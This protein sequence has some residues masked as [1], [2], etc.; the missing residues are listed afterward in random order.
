[1]GWVESPPLLCAVTKLAR[2]LTQHLVDKAVNL[3]PHPLKEVM[4]IQAVST[5]ARLAVPTKLLQVYVDDFCFATTQLMVETH[6]PSI[7]QAAIH[8]IH[9]FFPQPEVTGHQNEKE[10]I[11]CKKL[12]LGNGDYTSKKDIIG[13]TFDGIKRTFH[14]PP[15]E[16]TAFIKVTHGLLCRTLA[17]LKTLQTLLV[18]SGMRPLFACSFFSPINAAMH[19]G[20]KKIGLGQ[21][22][23]IRSALGDLSCLLRLLSAQPT[24]VCELVIDMLCYVGYHDAAAE[25]ADGVRFSLIH[26]MPPL[27]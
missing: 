10:S 3:P 9:S 4:K 24:H 25:G 22:S 15:A 20:G 7:H 21:S 18:N 16:A 19:G 12:D 6:I 8:G 17:P 13:F 23:D 2:D 5:R 26:D 27:V 11:S 14:L 1:M